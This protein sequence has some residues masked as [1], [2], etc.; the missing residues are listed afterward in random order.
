M[1]LFIATTALAYCSLGTIVSALYLFLCTP[2]V[3]I[4]VFLFLYGFRF[5]SE[6]STEKICLTALKELYQ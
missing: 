6:N 2:K 3:L 4:T 1:T 5:F